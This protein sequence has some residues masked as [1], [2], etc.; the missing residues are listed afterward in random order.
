MTGPAEDKNP[1]GGRDRP[2]ESERDDQNRNQDHHT[3]RT[4]QH[5]TSPRLLE[6]LVCPLTKTTLHISH[7]RT[8]LLSRAAGLAYPIRDGIPMLTSEAARELSEDELKRL[9]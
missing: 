4:Q 2:Q 3:A 1:Q 8:E 9:K 5:V 7:D 6:F